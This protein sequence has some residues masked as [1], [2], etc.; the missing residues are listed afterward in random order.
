[1]LSISASIPIDTAIDNYISPYRHELEIAMNEVI[2]FAPA[3]L[4]HNRNL[5]ET[6]LSNFFADA[7]LAVGREI[8]PEVSFSLATKDGIRSSISKGDVTIGSVFSLM[9][10]ENLIT[11]LELKGSDVITLGE[12]IAENN[13]QPVGNIKM[14]IK[15]SKIVEF[16]INNQPVD[17]NKTYKMVTYDF[18]ANGG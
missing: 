12:F 15:Q 9:P 5:P 10:F 2:G 17:P 16:L 6:E 18:I 1:M 7:L 13:G 8:D 3:E 11:I 4:I 14:T